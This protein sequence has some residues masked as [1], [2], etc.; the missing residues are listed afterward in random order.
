MIIIGR[1]D[2]LKKLMIKNL[3]QENKEYDI[4]KIILRIIKNNYNQL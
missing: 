1:K 2:F 4:K 3:I